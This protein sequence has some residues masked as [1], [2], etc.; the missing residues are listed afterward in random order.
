MF[1]A[2]QY[3]AQNLP[4]P[5]TFSVVALRVLGWLVVGA[6]VA[7]ALTCAGFALAQCCKGDRRGR[8]PAALLVLLATLLRL[9]AVLDVAE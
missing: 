3:V 5:D 2:V 4:Q 1:D 7:I 6:A 9:D 8:I